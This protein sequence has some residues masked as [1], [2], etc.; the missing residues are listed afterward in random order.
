MTHRRF[1]QPIVEQEH[2]LGIVLG[3]HAFPEN[4]VTKLQ[5]SS[6]V[7]SPRASDRFD[8]LLSAM[9]TLYLPLNCGAISI[10]AFIFA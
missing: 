5:D 3:H 4:A 2:H 7:I 10:V 8:R 1:S 6:A 9:M